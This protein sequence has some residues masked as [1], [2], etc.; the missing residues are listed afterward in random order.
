MDLTA[1]S[2][3]GT[4]YYGVCVDPVA[5]ESDTTNNCSTAVSVTV[6]QTV[7]DTQGDPDLMVPEA[8]VSDGAP[9]VGVRFRLSA[10]VRNDGDG[11]ADTT[12]LYYYRSTDATITVSDTQVG[13]DAVVA[14]AASGSTG[15]WVDL[16]APSTPGTYYYGAC[17][18]TVS[19]ETDTTNNCSAAVKVTVPQ[20]P[21]PDLT[22]AQPSVTDGSP[23]TGAPFT[24]SATVSNGGTGE[25]AATTLRYYRSTDATISTTDTRVGTDQVVEL[26]GSGSAGQSVDLTAPSTP[27]IY[28][29]GACVDAVAGELDTTN[30]CSPSVTVTTLQPD[31]VVKSPAVN[32][33]NPETDA[34]F[35]LS[36]TVENDGEG[37]SDSAI[38]RYYSSTDATV[39][40]SDTQVGTESL[41]GLAA[42]ATSRQSVDLTAS[43]TP[44]THY[45]GACVDAVTDESDT[46][47]N[48]SSSVTV[49][50]SEAAQRDG[51]TVEIGVEDEKK[52]AP[53]GD[54]VDLSAEVLDEDGD[55]ITGATV[56]W[57]SSDPAIAT[58]NSSGVM[59]AVGT[60]WVTLTATATVSGSSTQSLRRSAF[61]ANSDT[62]VTGSVRM[63]VVE[64]VARIEIDPDSLSFDSVNASKT[65]TA[66]LYDADDNEMQPT[67]WGWSSANKEVATVRS[68]SLAS[69]ISAS[70]RSV[71]EGSTTVTLSANGSATG[72]ASVTVT[73]PTARVSVDPISLTFEALGVTKTV[74]VTVLD[75]NGDEDEDATFGYTGVFSPCCGIRPGDVIKSW[76]ITKV[77]DGLEVT[78]EGTGRGRITICSPSCFKSTDEEDEESEIE[79]AVVL[80]TIPTSL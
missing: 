66:T 10:T 37:E 46:T 5:D 42:A 14:L 76:D 20:P 17:A 63:H 1:P 2:T 8:S 13:S 62:T 54:T 31:L 47:N 65:L 29:Y 80:V 44:G 4:N 53:V 70:V 73:L 71:G 6:Q 68:D 64:P 26:A 75:E 32:K 9:A 56:T 36:V 24:L 43:S 34:Q 77:D 33:S 40:T 11:G 3:P 27:G 22:V 52:Y 16:T 12:T 25:S 67:Y 50:V 28:Y 60:G 35:T 45:Y 39:T 59:T 30:N 49:T 15:Q 61:A 48:C 7:I 38:L 41:A 55:E 23:A 57:S 69:G 58:V 51:P 74:T 79:D 78:A 21:R 19:D 18:A 72:T